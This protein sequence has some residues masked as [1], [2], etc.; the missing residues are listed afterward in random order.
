ML[1]GF[2]GHLI[3]ESFIERHLGSSL[4]NGS[5]EPGRHRL[6]R[7]RALSASLGPASSL[8]ALLEA[9]A[10]PLF[11]ELGF[12]GPVSV[13]PLKGTLAATLSTGSEPVALIVAPWG[14]R[15]DGS[16]RG[17]VVY[18]REQ[19]AS[20]CLLFNGIHA[21]VIE[22][23]RLYSRRHVQFD[24]DVTLDDERTSA[25]LQTVLQAGSF[26]IAGGRRESMLHRLVQSSEDDS[27]DVRRSLRH[28]VLHASADV[29][30][31][32]IARR[33]AA[34]I[35]GALEQALTIVYRILF[36]LFAEARGLVPLWH[37]IYR[38]SYSLDGLRA[39][40]ERPGPAPGL[41]DALRAISRLAHAGCRVGDLH[42]TPFNGRLFSPLRT[43]LAERHDLDDEAGRRA[44]L[45]L[46]TRTTVDHAGRERIAYRDLGVEQLGAV[47]ETVLDYEPRIAAMPV[48]SR[49][50][51]PPSHVGTSMHLGSDRRKSTGTFYTPQPIAQFLIRRTLGPLVRDA[52]PDTILG[53]KVLDP[54]MG[55]GAFLV[56]ACV[57]LAHAYEA[58][59][60][61]SGSCH[62]TDFGPQEHAAIRRTIA[63]RCLFG[64][65]LNP[66]AVQ[67]ACLSLWLATLAADRPL[68]F[69]DHHL[70]TGDSL[71]GTWL[72]C[73]SQPPAD[74]VR[75]RRLEP[76]PLFDEAA[77]GDAIRQ[78]LPVR[79]RLA[80]G[81]NDT[82]EQVR[83]KERAL[84]ALSRPDAAVSRWKRVAN[85]WCARWFS[86]P[87]TRVPTS[88]FGALS[89]QVLTGSGA[90]PAAIASRYLH[91][92][93]AIAASRRFFHWELEFPEAFFTANGERLASAGFDAVVTNPPWDMIR[94]DAGSA[95]DRE[96]HRRDTG[97]VLRFTRDAG[98]YASQSTGHA[99]RYQLFV[100]R[101]MALARPGGRVGLVLPSGLA[102]DHGSAPLRR[103][104][105]SRCAVD[106][107][108]GFDNRQAV[109][110]IHRSVRF[111]LLTATSGG[112]TTEIG[113]RL[114]EHDPSVLETADDEGQPAD[115]WFTLRLTPA[116]IEHL[117][118]RDLAI[119]DLRTPIDLAIA[120]R[121]AMLFPPLGD[122]RGWAAGFGR[123]L[124]A[125]DDRTSFRPAGRGQ[126]IVEGKQIEPFRVNLAAAR[127]SIGARD[128]RRLLASRHQRARLAYR[129]VAGPANRL[130][131]IAAVLP[132]GCVSTHTVFCLR[133]GLTLQAQHFLCWVFNS[134][135]VNYLV[136]LRVGTHVTTGIVERLPVPQ[137]QD[138]PAAFRAI[139]ATARQLARRHDPAALARLN[140]RVARLYQLSR[141]EFDHVVGTFPLVSREDRD[142]A[143]REFKDNW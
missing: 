131:L 96:R 103:M 57:Y 139:A 2:S 94:A 56:A 78:T 95:N 114:G 141:E 109:F 69:L 13:V 58:A 73:L 98:V 133:T 107:L 39:A 90:L 1:P 134:L 27:A 43:P 86:S 62:A 20:W 111:L 53:L 25:V 60:V 137:Q 126:P 101:A 121:A 127:C 105:L 82:L 48:S 115:S 97:A 49:R 51:P 72:A 34:A 12:A 24:L 18:A 38:E 80:S 79:F 19:A 118:G 135:V 9:G 54:A 99:N 120:E 140:A 128:A 50:T 65:D 59:L 102:V 63:E 112:P 89:D 22:T 108:V 91:D 35:D 125:T 55:S 32:L 136:R 110:P 11:R 44:L 100:E 68:T 52:A 3:S 61:R 132:P 23:N 7:C 143:L 84:A 74:R 138:A 64:V 8:R 45:A 47:Y 92:A 10:A 70:Q 28:G 37:P 46:A 66:M 33:P 31:A 41:W 124:N 4:T 106:G 40:A 76:L 26:S 21:R 6:L 123:E 16:W 36:L 142:G 88:A 5:S 104:L 87:A 116:L 67:L 42:V 75:S 113:C 29:L 119:P 93:E 83:A 117:S 30:G 122:G 15:L 81:P 14:Q 71:L 130:T 17:A 77:A 85:L 129:D